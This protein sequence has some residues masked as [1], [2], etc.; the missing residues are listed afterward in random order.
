ME[1]SWARWLMLARGCLGVASGLP[2]PPCGS[3]EAQAECR[4]RAGTGPA[5][6]AGSSL[7]PGRSRTTASARRRPAD[8]SGRLPG[9]ALGRAGA[10]CL[11]WGVEP[12]RHPR[13]AGQAG[14]E[15]P[16]EL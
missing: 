5:P 12:R 14:L 10:V 6:L 13:A 11:G 9:S 7:S 1:P 3:G 2:P 16:G 15:A 8:G 4:G